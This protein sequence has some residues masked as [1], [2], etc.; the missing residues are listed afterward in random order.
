MSVQLDPNSYKK[1]SSTNPKISTIDPFRATRSQRIRSDLDHYYTENSA[2]DHANSLGLPYVDL[3][4]MPVDG[5]VLVLISE[6]E[7]REYRIGAFAA[8]QKEVYVATDNPGK[9]GQEAIIQRLSAK[10]GSCKLFVCSHI[11]MEKIFRAY[12]TILQNKAPEDNITIDYS[13]ID[14]LSNISLNKIESIIS[15]QNVSEIIETILGVA[16][17]N[18]ASDIHLEPE[19]DT[20]NLR[21][22]L[23][24]V[25]HTFAHLPT[26]MQKL[27]ENR[28]KLLSHV[29]L[30]I[31][32]TPQDGRFS[33][34]AHERDVDVRVSLLPSNYG[35]SIVMRLLGT[36]AVELDLD[37][38]GFIGIG[39][40]RVLEAINKPQGMVI[41]TGPTGSGKTTTLYTFLNNLNTGENKIITLEDPIEYKLP[42]ISQTQIDTAA[43][44]TFAGG[45]RAILRQDPDIVMVGEIRDKETADTAVEAALTGHLVLSTMHTND[46]AGA[47]PRL[48]ELEIKGFLLADSLSALIAQ[49]L[50][51]RLCVHCKHEVE[52]TADE[53]KFVTQELLSIPDSAHVIL[54]QTLQFYTSDGCDQCNGLGYKGRIGAYEVISITPGLRY[55]VSEQFPSIQQVREVAVKE[56]MITMTQ[57]ALLKALQ[58]IT[59][60][61]EIQRNL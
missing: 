24:G 6:E 29:K 36:G 9:S 32:N 40:K 38:L 35:Y 1:S 30:N 27:I 2:H 50:I 55:L 52:L 18:N 42:G 41:T 59:D 11:S 26:Q 44:Y 21:F 56:G 17:Q 54:P 19:K 53:K 58:G 14:V 33:F 51:R 47:I 49:R 23:D 57:D 3:Y 22:R 20:Y 8:K 31:D 4:G 61:K 7:A 34:R 28:I 5:S 25:L 45:L 10:G 16:I 46:A 37:E 13:K 48:M 60:I 43:G 12:D 39:E 15:N